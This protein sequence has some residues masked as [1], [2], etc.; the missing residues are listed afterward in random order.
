[1]LPSQVEKA[2]FKP[3]L[4]RIVLLAENRHRQLRR[5]AEN[6]NFVDIDL[7]LPGGQV[8]I[9]SAC[10]P[11]AHLAVDAHDPFRAQCL[12]QLKGLAVRVSNDLRQAV[13]IAQVNKKNTTVIADAMTPAREPH[14][15]ADIALA[16]CAAGMGAITM[17]RL[18]FA[19]AGGRSENPSVKRG[20]SAWGV[21]FVKANGVRK[22]G[23]PQAPRHACPWPAQ[24]V[25]SD[26][27]THA[28]IRKKD[29][30]AAPDDD[31]YVD[32]RSGGG[33]SDRARA[34]HRLCAPRHPQRPSV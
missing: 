14:D 7:D 13:M 1:M 18:I 22:I 9:F 10:W 11:L 16:K 20:K 31:R 23:W 25:L 12:G 34:R 32:R 2:I 33:D 5:G 3:D 27:D 17:H 29:K 19:L 4:F 21:G 24:L 28:K 15:F 6:L 26:Q 8:R 30:E